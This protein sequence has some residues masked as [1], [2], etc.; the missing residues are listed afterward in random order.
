MVKEK[1]RI[2]LFLFRNKNSNVKMNHKIQK[3]LAS[4]KREDFI[5]F[6]MRGSNMTICLARKLSV[7]STSKSVNS[8]Y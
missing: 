3:H 7:C 5:C 2:I 4:T 8:H 1:V 6:P